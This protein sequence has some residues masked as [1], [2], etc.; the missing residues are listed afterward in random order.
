MTFTGLPHY[1]LRFRAEFLDSCGLSQLQE[2]RTFTYYEVMRQTI[3]PAFHWAS[4][5]KLT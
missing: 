1:A 5:F 3:A 4:R 2:Q